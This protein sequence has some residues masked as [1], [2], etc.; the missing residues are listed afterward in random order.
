MGVVWVGLFVVCCCLLLSEDVRRE[1][2]E[3]HR[4]ICIQL[5]LCYQA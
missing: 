1:W 4:D 5:M 3:Q 2:N